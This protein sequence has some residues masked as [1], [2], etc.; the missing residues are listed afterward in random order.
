MASLYPDLKQQ[1]V[2]SPATIAVLIKGNVQK[3]RLL[4]SQFMWSWFKL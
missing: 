2:S 3:P 4:K 1:L